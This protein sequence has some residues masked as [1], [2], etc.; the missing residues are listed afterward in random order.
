ML[1]I[2]NTHSNICKIYIYIFVVVVVATHRTY[3]DVM[4]LTRI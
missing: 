3:G 2:K 1:L 4:R